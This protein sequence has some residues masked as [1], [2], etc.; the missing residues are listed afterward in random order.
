VR[1]GGV[2]LVLPAGAIGCAAAPPPPEYCARLVVGGTSI[3]FHVTTST[4][5]G[6]VVASQYYVKLHS[7]KFPGGAVRGQLHPCGSSN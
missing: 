7:L 6:K 1:C 3:S 4:N 5:L 2:F